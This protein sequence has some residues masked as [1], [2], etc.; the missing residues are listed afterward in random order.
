[1]RLPLM[2][3]ASKPS[4]GAMGRFGRVPGSPG[5][6]T[7]KQPDESYSNRGHFSYKWQDGVIAELHGYWS[8]DAQ[9][10]EAAAYAAAN[11]PE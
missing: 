7:A 11:A 10:A 4:T 8:E 6:A 5:R 3:Q 2:M 9:N 1:M